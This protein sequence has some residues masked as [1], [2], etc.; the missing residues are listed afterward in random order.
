MHFSSAPSKLESSTV[1]WPMAAA[2]SVALTCGR[3]PRMR[4]HDT[5]LRVTALQE[6]SKQAGKQH[7]L[8]ASGSSTICS[9]VRRQQATKPSSVVMQDVADVL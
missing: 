2:A 1:C 3:Q 6:C 9:G 7:G 4:A 8:L 5:N